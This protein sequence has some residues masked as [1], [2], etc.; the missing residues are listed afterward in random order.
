MKTTR[1]YS[2][3][4]HDLHRLAELAGIS[5]SDEQVN[6]LDKIFSFADLFI[7]HRPTTPMAKKRISKKIEKVVRGYVLRLQKE[8]KI[9]VSR[10]LV[11]GSQVTGK[12]HPGSDIDVCIISPRFASSLKE[13]Q[14]L[15]SI[16]NREEVLAGLEPVGYSEE[17]FLAG[18]SLINEIQRTGVEMAI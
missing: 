14:L 3:Y 8:K 7:R 5:P 13:W 18:S 10:V 4:T 1:E 6:L 15:F 16:R 12:T 2:P 9:P 17:D 11:Y